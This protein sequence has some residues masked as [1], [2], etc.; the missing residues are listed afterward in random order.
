LGRHA[1]LAG[2][3]GARKGNLSGRALRRRGRAILTASVDAPLPRNAEAI[4]IVLA[5]VLANLAHDE[6]AVAAGR[7]QVTAIHE[8]AIRVVAREL[9]AAGIAGVAVCQGFVASAFTP[10]PAATLSALGLSA[11]GLSGFSSLSVGS[12]APA[13]ALPRIS[14]LRGEIAQNLLLANALRQRQT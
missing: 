9:T 3:V 6:I 14:A 2:A 1:P 5:A 4:V 11:L 7:Q 10:A 12:R 13:R 8:R